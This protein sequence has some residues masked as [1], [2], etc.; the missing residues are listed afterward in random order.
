MKRSAALFALI[1]SVVL[2]V[3]TGLPAG[4]DHTD[5]N[6]PLTPT[7]GDDPNPMTEGAG[8]WTFIR[9]FGN[10]E[11][12]TD[13]EFFRR[14]GKL[15]GIGGSLGQAV[16]DLVVGQRFI[17]LIRRTGEVA[18][19]W[20]ADHGS[21]HCA[22]GSTSVTGLQHDQQILRGGGT[23]LLSD[24]TDAMSR[25]HDPG[26]GG[27][28][29]VDVSN[30]GKNSFEPREIHLIRFAGFTHT[31]TVD[32]TRPW[33]L[34]SS[35]SDFAG[36][37]WIEVVD[38]RSCLGLQGMSLAEKRE[39]C[40]PVVYRIPFQPDWSR[41]R[42]SQDG[43][44]V[45]GSESACHDITSRGS[46]LYCAGLN[47]TLI[48]DVANLTRAGGRVRGEPLPCNVIDGTDTDAKVTDC[49]TGIANSTPDDPIQA[50]GWDFLGAFNHPGRDCL[51]RPPDA[52]PNTNCNSNLFVESDD[53][54]SVSHEADP[55]RRGKYMFVTDERGGG[56]VPPG[57]S[58]S[59]SIDNPFGNGGIHAF[60]TRNPA[61]IKYAMLHGTE[62]KAVWRS[63]NVVPAATFCDVHVI[64][65]IPGE[66][67]FIVA[68][69]SSGAKI[70][71]Y[72]IENGRFIFRET[73]SIVLPGANTWAVEDFKIRENRNGSRTYWFMATDIDRG[74]D[75]YRWR[76]RPNPAG[77][78]PPASLV[79]PV[80]A[81]SVDAALLIGGLAGLP[82]AALVG[83]RRRAR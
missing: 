62:D 21:A 70:L 14:G 3:G 81:M 27:V 54:V 1:L 39:A 40:R 32:A 36:R 5:P 72:W 35:S 34:Y 19:K 59:E 53:G 25:C 15:Y 37:P 76:G 41:Q 52:N 79:S 28:E 47:A 65:K 46:R 20:R 66:Q 55:I 73:A 80:R 26:G 24:T 48:F 64:E 49:A 38:A 8:N 77:S 11:N 22:P 4:A 7:A 45:P 83:R 58:C 57:A 23:I 74:I 68:Y 33:I 31:N 16:D 60:N 12:G 6:Q 67:R 10:P 9:N 43:D 17:R 69:Y 56:V 50:A 51:P 78:E 42:D 61:N 13:L 75:I 18:P 82:L 2:V 44:L 29:L 63:D 71:D 30:I